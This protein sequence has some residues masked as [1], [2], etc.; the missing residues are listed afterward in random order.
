M[1]RETA[2]EACQAG[3][4]E[5][6]RDYDGI[7]KLE[8]RATHRKQSPP[9]E[10]LEECGKRLAPVA[11]LAGVECDKKDGDLG[12][13]VGLGQTVGIPEGDQKGEV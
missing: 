11:D 7:A 3:V 9:R 10:Q 1:R 2:T 8:S 6:R 5:P 13:Q 12:Q 4:S